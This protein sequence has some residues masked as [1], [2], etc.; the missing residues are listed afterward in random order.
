MKGV[1]SMALRARINNLAK[2]KGISPQLAMQSFFAE[3]FIARIAVSPYA[4]NL[5]LK[6]GALVSGILGVAA[7]TTMDVDATVFGLKATAGTVERMMEEIAGIDAGDGIR[8]VRTGSAAEGI[9]KE[10]GYGGFGIA[11][12]A[13][14]G[15]IRQP[16]SV[17]VTF[18][19]AIT[20]GAEEREIVSCVDDGV[21]MRVLAYPVETVM[22]EKVE[23]ILRRGAA[24]TRP[25]DFYDLHKLREAGVCRAEVLPEAV[26]RTVERRGSV[27]YAKRW[28]EIL[29]GVAGSQFQKE[30]WGRYA[31]RYRYAEGIGFGEV[32]A[33][34][35]AVFRL[36][37][38]E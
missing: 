26:R 35:E 5:A 29:G 2:R 25:R 19:D 10:D 6:G 14:F 27:E 1:N 33:S 18:G 22:A 21:R 8:F 23:T 37:F 15:T 34:V 3:R 30:Q 13:Q 16:L 7:R 28:R 32:M 38:G 24:T 11:F 12:L 17:D 9:R 20:P 31:G 4:G 36:A